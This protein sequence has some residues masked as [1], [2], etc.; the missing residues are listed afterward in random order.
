VGNSAW[1][2]SKCLFSGRP[3]ANELDLGV[4][5]GGASEP[6]RGGERKKKLLG[7]I[8]GLPHFLQRIFLPESNTCCWVGC[9]LFT[10]GGDGEPLSHSTSVTFAVGPSVN[11]KIFSS[12][13]ID[14]FFY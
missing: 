6:K 8:N 10:L 7:I 14:F 13:F 4:S 11:S 9:D 2:P 12:D 1:P 5:L 3:S